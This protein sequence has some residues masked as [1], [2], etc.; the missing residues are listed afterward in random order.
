[1]NQSYQDYTIFNESNININDW[2]S[3]NSRIDYT[4]YIQSFSKDAVSFPLWNLS[5][6]SYVNKAKK[7]RLYCSVFDLLNQN[8]GIQRNSNLNYI[9]VSKTNV[10][11]RYFMIGLSYNI[12]GFKKNSGLEIKVGS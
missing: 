5:I 1:M 7:L 11:G 9:Q 2:I 3:V 8:K 10:L 6:T 12:K 4:T